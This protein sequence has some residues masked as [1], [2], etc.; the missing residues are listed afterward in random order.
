MVVFILNKALH[1]GMQPVVVK[2]DM[3]YRSSVQTKH[4]QRATR[5]YCI[6]WS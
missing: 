1:H 2:C 6:T 4:V 3:N 5:I